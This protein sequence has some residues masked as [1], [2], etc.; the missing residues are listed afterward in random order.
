MC[1]FSNKFLTLKCGLG[2]N[3]VR[4]FQI[5]ISPNTEFKFRVANYKY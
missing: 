1:L 3:V 2:R 5:G 4:E